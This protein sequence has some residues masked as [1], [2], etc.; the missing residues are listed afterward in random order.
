M[1]SHYSLQSSV[2]I[3]CFEMTSTSPFTFRYCFETGN[4]FAIGFPFTVIVLI[5]LKLSSRM[6]ISM[7]YKAFSTPDK[8]HIFYMQS[9]LLGLV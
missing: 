7:L 9:G 3:I 4:L 8:V 5:E 2:I 6:P 1:D